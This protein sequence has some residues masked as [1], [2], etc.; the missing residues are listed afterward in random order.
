MT[1]DTVRIKEQVDL[2]ALVG[3]DVHLRKVASTGGGEYAGPCLKCGGEDRFHVS[4]S[5]WWF[6]RQCHERRGD[7]IA[8]LM[9]RDGTTFLDACSALGNAIAATNSKGSAKRTPV[10]PLTREHDTEPPSPVWQNQA[11][12]FVA[13]TVEQL[14]QNDAA[15]AYLRGRGL[16][17]ETTRS[18]KLGYNPREMYRDG[19][20]WGL[21]PEAGGKE[22]RVWL[23]RGWVIPCE[24]SNHLRYVKVRRANE[25]AGNAAKY[26][27]ISGSKKAGVIYG[28]DDAR[29]SW[30]VVLCEGEL[31]ALV[32]RQELA[33]VAAV[34]SVGDAGNLPGPEAIA[35][36]GTVQ[37]WWAVFDQD[38]AGQNGA[39]KW[40]DLSQRVQPLAWPWRDRGQKYDVND[41]LKDGENLAA[42]V[43]PCIGPSD[44]AKRRAWARTWL[45][46]LR[47]LA[48][49]ESSPAWRAWRAMLTEYEA[50][51]PE[52]GGGLQGA[53]EST[54]AETLAGNPSPQGNNAWVWPAILGPGPWHEISAPDWAP[55]DLT[56]WR[57]WFAGPTNEVRSVT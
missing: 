34:I 31:N 8:Y 15:L 7:A 28:L 11:G 13:W 43:I 52:C 54:T 30:D 51:G 57:R 10:T 25:L 50:M 22:R 12:K 19:S 48:G 4:A 5:G 16:A 45:E 39:M 40:G 29:G 17:D 20:S 55:E 47:D 6:C 35:I 56:G 3:K 23:P 9:W 36:L 2:V 27:A 21:Q 42:W 24:V 46:R 32:L 1:I 38:E 53:V 37:R 18:A 26:I 41:A 44:P 49:D 33:G 14:W